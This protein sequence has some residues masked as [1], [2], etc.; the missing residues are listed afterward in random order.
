MALVF[1]GCPQ[2][3]RP[4]VVDFCGHAWKLLSLC[5]GSHPLS[6]FFL[7]PKLD[8]SSPTS[9][10]YSCMPTCARASRAYD[11]CGGRACVGMSA[12]VRTS[13]SWPAKFSRYMRMHVSINTGAGGIV[14]IPT[15]TCTPT[16]ITKGR[17]RAP[18]ANTI[19]AIPSNTLPSLSSIP[20]TSSPTNP[21]SCLPVPASYHSLV[22]HNHCNAHSE[23]QCGKPAKVAACL[24]QP[25]RACIR[26]YFNA[27]HMQLKTHLSMHATLH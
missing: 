6:R 23:S 2:K 22:V 8:A 9:I 15:D 25:T 12:L 7:P 18:N 4:V 24:L 16:F 21:A 13:F 10:G 3:V 27:R 17:L 5:P 14:P 26:C 1:Q 19:C 11:A 20:A